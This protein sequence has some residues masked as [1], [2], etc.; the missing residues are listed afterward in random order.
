MLAQNWPPFS[1]QS[2]ERFAS[3]IFPGKYP[4]LPIISK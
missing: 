1:V 2:A 3:V 4:L